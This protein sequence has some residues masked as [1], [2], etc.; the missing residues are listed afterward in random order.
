MR[1]VSKTVSASAACP[2]ERQV[3]ATSQKAGEHHTGRLEAEEVCPP[4]V[5]VAFIEQDTWKPDAGTEN[6]LDDQFE[7]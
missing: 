3:E 6:T 5:G 2:E 7:A 1:T 4:L